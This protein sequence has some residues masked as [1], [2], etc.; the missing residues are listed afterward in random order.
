M[1]GQPQHPPWTAGLTVASFDVVAWYT[2]G[3]SSAA[4]RLHHTVKPA[5]NDHLMGYFSAF[6]SSSRWPKATQ[7]SSSRQR[8]LARVNGYLQS[9]SKHITEL[10]TGNKSYNRGGRY[11]QVSLY[12]AR[13]EWRSFCSF[14][15][16]S[17]GDGIVLSSHYLNRFWPVSIT[18]YDVTG[19][20]S[21]S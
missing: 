11:R 13:P 16:C 20:A 3:L 7:M 10:I 1:D 15:N 4:K 19:Y 2:G 21:V 12:I 18:P 17:S 5:Y 9:S 8:L 14:G 6:W